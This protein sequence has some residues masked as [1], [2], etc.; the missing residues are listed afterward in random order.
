MSLVQHVSAIEGIDRE[1]LEAS[2]GKSIRRVLS[3]DVFPQPDD[4]HPK[5]SVAAYNVSIAKR[6]GIQYYLFDVF[7]T[8]HFIA[9]VVSTVLACWLASGIVFGFAA[10]KPVL[11]AEGVYEWLCHK[12]RAG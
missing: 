11:L 4:A 7:K 5:P 6:I 2:P 3:Y 8:D 12:K 1:P 9:Q 10:L